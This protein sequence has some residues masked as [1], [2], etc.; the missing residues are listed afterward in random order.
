MQ[1]NFFWNSMFE[2]DQKGNGVLE[3]KTIFL[4]LTE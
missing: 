1:F 4:M 3:T 2:L